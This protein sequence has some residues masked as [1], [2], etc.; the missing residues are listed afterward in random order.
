MKRTKI[1]VAASTLA[2][3]VAGLVAAKANKKFTGPANVDYYDG[4]TYSS[5][6][7]VSG[8]DIMVTTTV[9]AGHRAYFTQASINYY[10]YTAGTSHAALYLASGF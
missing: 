7:S 1:F 2:L 9:G 6:W 4:S 5:M 8:N 10:L 3:L